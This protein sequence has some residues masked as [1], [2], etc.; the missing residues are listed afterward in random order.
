MSRCLGSAI[1]YY[2]NI[3]VLLYY[4]FVFITVTLYAMLP[5]YDTFIHM[6]TV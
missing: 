4:I 5:I 6:S 3:V 2:N 1:M